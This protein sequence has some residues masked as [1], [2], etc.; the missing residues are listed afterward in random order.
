VTKFPKELEYPTELIIP[1]ATAKIFVPSAT[2][3]SIPS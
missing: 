1:S 3:I 2:P